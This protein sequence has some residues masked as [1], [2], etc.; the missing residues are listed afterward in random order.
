MTNP[1]RTN[2]TRGKLEAMIERT[3]RL[4]ASELPRGAKGLLKEARAKLKVALS[5][6]ED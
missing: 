2:K 4:L 1:Y 5:K 6:W 3:E